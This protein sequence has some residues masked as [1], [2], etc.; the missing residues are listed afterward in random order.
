MKPFDLDAALSGAPVVTRDGREVTQL[1]K[2]D[3]RGLWSLIGVIDREIHRWTVYGTSS[4]PEAA[5]EGINTLLMAP[6]KKTGWVARYGVHAAWANVIRISEE[7]Y[8][9]EEEAKYRHPCADGYHKIEW[10]E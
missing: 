10:D 3:V 6:V 5:G 7:A 8:E 1:T 9:S 2:F 4:Y